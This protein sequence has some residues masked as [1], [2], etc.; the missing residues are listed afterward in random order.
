MNAWRRRSAIAGGG[1]TLLTIAFATGWHLGQGSITSVGACGDAARER[2]QFLASV[3]PTARLTSAK[4][5]SFG[6][7]CLAGYAYETFTRDGKAK[8]EFVVIDLQDGIPVFLHEAS[9]VIVERRSLDAEKK[10]TPREGRVG[11]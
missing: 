11:T 4:W 8:A 6:R 5:K 1:A 10:N 9:K 2:A 3:N 7:S